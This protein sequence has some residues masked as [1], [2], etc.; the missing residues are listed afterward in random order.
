VHIASR[1]LGQASDNRI[2]V[3][4]TVKDLVVGSG[5]EFTDQGVYNLKGVPGE[6]SLFAVE[7]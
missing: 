4:R 6:W 2:W 5:Y 1:V 3:S 7:L